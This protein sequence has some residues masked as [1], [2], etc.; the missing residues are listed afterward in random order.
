MGGR[1]AVSSVPEGTEF[2]WHPKPVCD[3]ANGPGFLNE[4]AVVVALCEALDAEMQRLVQDAM[5]PLA[6]KFLDE[7]KVAGDDEPKVSFMIAKSSDE[8]SSQLRKLMSLEDDSEC[9]APCRLMLI[10]IPDDGAFYEGPKGEFTSAALE[11]FVS[12][13]LSGAAERKQLQR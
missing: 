8:I 3:L 1:E 13:F 11:D 2:P 7:A 6:R 10:N 4:T 9:S 12:S 5:E